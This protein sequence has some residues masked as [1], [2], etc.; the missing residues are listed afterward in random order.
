M[1][2]IMGIIPLILAAVGIAAAVAS[3]T[4]SVVVADKQKDAQ[5]K[6]NK[7][8]ELRQLKSLTAQRTAD[9]KAANQARQ[10]AARGMLLARI[11][12]R[13]T[14]AETAALNRKYAGKTGTTGG[15]RSWVHRGSYHLGTPSE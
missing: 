9:K 14:E 5:A 15:I 7:A 13:Q 1:L 3:T 2:G 6:A 8:A 12:T 10:A 4:A 11:D